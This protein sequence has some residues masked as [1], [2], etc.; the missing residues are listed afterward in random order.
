MRLD[1]MLTE[2]GFPGGGAA[3][4]P[5]IADVARRAD[6]GGFGSVW[7]TDH[8]FQSEWPGSGRLASDPMLEAYTTL[9]F[10]AGHTERVRLGAMVSPVT[11]RQP[12][13]LAKIVTTLDVL[14]GGRAALGIGAGWDEREHRGLGIPFP[15]L[16]ERFQRLEETLRIV[17]QM[18][19]DEDGPFDGEHYRLEETIC[20]PRPI[21]QPHP[22][23]VV[24]GGG[25]R[26]TLRLVARYADA[27]NL[28]PTPE[29]PRKLEVLRGHCADVGR[30]YDDIERTVQLFGNVSTGGTDGTQTPDQ[31]LDTLADLAGNGIDRAILILP[32]PAMAA[33][34]DLLG[35]RVLPAAAGLVTAGR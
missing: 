21:S 29:L 20:E 31:L 3:T 25:E 11:F 7:V 1:V 28:Y 4:G 19:S 24:G 17:R 18:W 2:Y 26:K 32:G 12:G 15:P 34:V 35:E 23:I 8:L 10:A 13:V 14:S 30:D 16:A 22:P 9:A 5:A 27:C 6:A 33:T